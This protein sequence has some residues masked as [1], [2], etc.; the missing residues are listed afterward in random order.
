MCFEMKYNFVILG[1]IKVIKRCNS[2]YKIFYCLLDFLCSEIFVVVVFV[3][4]LSFFVC[5]IS[6]RVLYFKNKIFGYELLCI[7]W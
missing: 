7:V 3:V 2:N 6:F 5:V 4:F 1:F